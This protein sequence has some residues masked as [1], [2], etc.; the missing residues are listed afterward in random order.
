MLYFTPITSSSPDVT[1]KL[2][3]VLGVKK[4]NVTKGLKVRWAETTPSG[5]ME[6][7]EERFLWVGGRDE[8]FARLVGWNS[9]RWMKV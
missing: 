3:D 1:I 8:L 9:K 2:E 5:I 6:T 7:N 4:S